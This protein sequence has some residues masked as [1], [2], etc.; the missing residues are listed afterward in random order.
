M[1]ERLEK[2]GGQAEQSLFVFLLLEAQDYSAT[3]VYTER[4]YMNP[5][6]QG[7]LLLFRKWMHRFKKEKKVHKAVC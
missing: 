2:I 3:L 6:Q 7:L 4:T 1:G 5:L